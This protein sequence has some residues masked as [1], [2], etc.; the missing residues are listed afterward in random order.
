MQRRDDG[1]RRDT[2]L[3]IGS[4]H[5]AAVVKRTQFNA[6]RKLKDIHL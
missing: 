3:A 1:E 2:G 6:G 4:A 5:R